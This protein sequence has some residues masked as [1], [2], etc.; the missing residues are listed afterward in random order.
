[1]IGFQTKDDDDYT[2]DL[3]GVNQGACHIYVRV[4][5]NFTPDVHVANVSCEFILANDT[6]TTRVLSPDVTSS[7]P[8]QIC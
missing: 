3:G 2:M 1:M 6:L 7:D 4:A 5:D 8:R